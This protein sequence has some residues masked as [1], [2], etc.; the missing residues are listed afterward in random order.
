[1]QFV[2]WKG[3]WNRKW[4]LGNYYGNKKCGFSY[5]INTGCDKCTIPMWDADNR[6]MAAGSMRT[7]YY[8]GNFS[9][10]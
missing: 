8:L 2:F 5:A 4:A 6:K 7:L 10:I 3:S 9:E 1:M